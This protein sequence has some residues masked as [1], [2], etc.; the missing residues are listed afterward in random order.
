MLHAIVRSSLLACL[1]GASLA[2]SARAGAQRPGAPRAKP[3]PH[4]PLGRLTLDDSV[5]E[6]A[7]IA[8]EAPT[9]R[10]GE[11]FVVSPGGRFA[12]IALGDTQIVV[13]DRRSHRARAM[14]GIP[15]EA[16]IFTDLAWADGHTL[17]FDRW[18][19]PHV[20]M[21]YAVDAARGRLLGAM[22]FH[23]RTLER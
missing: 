13:L 1:I 18:A 22:S 6:F 5:P 7:M 12:A 19:T 14:R 3:H 20:G 21:H 8:T 11:R 15:V 10:G 9:P 4:A 17:T 16:R 23:D 2:S